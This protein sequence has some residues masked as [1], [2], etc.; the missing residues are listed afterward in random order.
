[1]GGECVDQ[2]IKLVSPYECFEHHS[3]NDNIYNG[4]TLNYIYQVTLIQMM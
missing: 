4:A 1:V 2:V 3:T